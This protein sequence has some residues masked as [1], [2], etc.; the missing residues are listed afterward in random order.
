MG[1]RYQSSEE[2]VATG[3]SLFMDVLTDLLPRSPQAKRL[4]LPFGMPSAT[5][6]ELKKS[7]WVII[8][9]LVPEKDIHSEAR[10]LLCSHFW[11]EGGVHE[12]TNPQNRGG[13]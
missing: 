4:Y 7:G 10:R 11:L 6:L 5:S 1:G 9:G 12:L 3:F 13:D 8:Q 2:E